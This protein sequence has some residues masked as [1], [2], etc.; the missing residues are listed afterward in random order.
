MGQNYR[1]GDHFEALDK[2]DF[3]LVKSPSQDYLK[4]LPEN[5][6]DYIL[7]DPPHGNRI[8]YLELSLLWNSWLK[9]NVDFE[10]EIIISE[11]KDRKKDKNNYNTLMYSVFKECYRVLKP[12]KNCLLCSIALMMM[13]G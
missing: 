3:I 6:I 10:K 12:E 13:L 1:Q 8:P 5:S 4:S 11:S 7:T 2:T 9:E